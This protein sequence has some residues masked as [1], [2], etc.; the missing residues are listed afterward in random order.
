MSSWERRSIANDAKGVQK[1]KR[2]EKALADRL[3]RRPS[4]L[5]AALQPD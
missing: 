3:D 4:A 1:M 5:I 2:D